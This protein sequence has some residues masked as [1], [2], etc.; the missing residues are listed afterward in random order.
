MLVLTPRKAQ[1]VVVSGLPSRGAGGAGWIM[2]LV[3]NAINVCLLRR[4]SFD[5]VLLLQLTP[6]LF[7]VAQAV[8]VFMSWP[9]GG[10]K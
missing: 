9:V 7:A 3:W 1:S 5:S 8:H 2:L 10:G 4:T 6:L